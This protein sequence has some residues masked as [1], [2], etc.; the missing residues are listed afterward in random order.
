MYDGPVIDAFLHA[1]WIGRVDPQRPRADR[2]DWH[3]DPRL[4]R[5]MRTFRHTDRDSGQ[6]TPVPEAD[7]LQAMDAAGVARGI[8][9]SKVYYPAALPEVENVHH[10]MQRVSQAS[11]GRLKW[12]GTLVP[13]EHG[14]GS[15]W[16]LMRNSRLVD[17]LAD[18]AGFAGI[19][20][21]PAPWSLPPNDRWYYPIYAKCVERDATL[22]SYVGMP[23]PLWPMGPNNPA[24]LE[25]VALAFPELR[26][27]AHHIGDPWTDIA[28]RL[29]ARHPNVY[30][31]TSAWT[32]KAY[33]AALLE[34]LR[35]RWHG[36]PGCE[37]VLFATDYPML[38]L[39]R[40]TAQARALPL[41]D[42]QLRRFLYDNAAALLWA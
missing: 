5:V 35:G 33:P 25:D 15:Y 29:A 13:P 19:H 27:V 1:P 7:V 20:I 30:L 17:S 39:D 12:L 41:D 9:A 3:D 10:E 36:T 23:G 38:A 32:P 14:A 28:V 21:T 11:G 42:G 34:F 16:D 40:T 2:N 22:F 6:A 31:C 4:H 18:R 24:H 26:I 8:L 37:K